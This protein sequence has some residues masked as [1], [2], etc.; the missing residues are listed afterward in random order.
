MRWA[1]QVLPDSRDDLLDVR[2]D[3]L[4]LLEQ[5]PPGLVKE[6]LAID[7]IGGT[8]MLGNGVNAWNWER[9]YKMKL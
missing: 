4:G 1:A 2:A 8:E 3:G 5:L 6:E 9:K 7:G